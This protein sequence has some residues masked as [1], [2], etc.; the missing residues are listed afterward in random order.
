MIWVYL[1]YTKESLVKEEKEKRFKVIQEN[2]ADLHLEEATWEGVQ[3][4]WGAG[5]GGVNPT[6][7]VNWILSIT[8]LSLEVNFSSTSRWES[9]LISALW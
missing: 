4:L 2:T 9:T 7:A 1:I 5:S 6:T 3:W 8:W